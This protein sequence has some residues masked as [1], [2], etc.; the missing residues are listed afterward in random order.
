MVSQL[1][2]SLLIKDTLTVS[3]PWNQG[4]KGYLSQ[5]EPY[6]KERD[7]TVKKHCLSLTCFSPSASA[8]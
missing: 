5:E 3:G 2:T 8:F 1:K 4:D 7:N 6:R